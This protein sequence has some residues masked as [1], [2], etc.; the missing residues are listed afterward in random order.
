MSKSFLE[1]AK[2]I[3]KRGPAWYND[4]TMANTIPY[5]EKLNPEQ[6]AAATHLDG[7]LL[8]LAGAG[9]GKTAAMTSR[10]A[11]LIREKHVW[12]SEILA[13]TF[14]NKAAGEMRERVESLIG[15]PSTGMWLL[16]F[17]SACLRVLRLYAD[18]IGYDKN[19]AVYDT[20]D[21]K[22]LMKQV[23][24][25]KNID[26]KTYTPA[27]FLGVISHYKEDGKGPERIAAEIGNTSRGK[28]IADVYDAYQKALAKNNAM[29]FDDLLWK[30]VILLKREPEVLERLQNR[31]RYVMVDE[32]QDTNRM[33]YEFVKMLAAKNRNIVVVGDDDQCIY[34]WRGADISNILNFEKDFPNAKVIKLE[35][36]YRSYGN[37][38]DAAYS[39]I[40]N[41][42]SRKEKKLWTSRA[43][44]EKIRYYR[45]DDDWD[46]ARYVAREIQLLFGKSPLSDRVRR[47]DNGGRGATDSL[48]W[49]DFAVLYRTNAQSRRF[50]EVFRSQGI[51]FR[52][53]NDLG[54]YD[55]KEIR[56]L[57]AYLRLV[58]NPADDIALSRIINE[59]K[60]SIGD[61]S[62]ERIRA[63]AGLKGVPMLK[64]LEDPEVRDILSAKAAVSVEATVNLLGDLNAEQDNLKVSD[65]YVQLLKKTGYEQALLDKQGDVESEKRLENLD[66]LLND[67]V[68]Y[69]KTCE[70][71]GEDAT[72]AGFL[73]G[74]SLEPGKNAGDE[75]GGEA[76]QDAVSLMTL[77]TA[78]GLEFPVV[79]LVG[80]D[81]GL[82]PGFRV[83]ERPEG[84]EEE[85]RLCYVGMTRAMAR[86]YL[87]SAERRTIYGSSSYMRESQ[88]LREVDQSLLEGSAI[89]R[90]KRYDPYARVT[91]RTES[92]TWDT[93]A[94]ARYE[95]PFAR[96]PQ[97]ARQTV[98]ESDLAVGDRVEHTKFG[99]GTIL[100][101]GSGMA[102][103]MFDDAGVKKLALSVAPLKKL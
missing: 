96:A 44:G 12:P 84:I 5:L 79:F 83:N 58:N 86:L 94:K 90:G 34:E 26:E 76:A 52:L 35:Q 40:K 71:R 81:D 89:D 80:L 38:L 57:M 18:R 61:K 69:E 65:I 97:P 43:S 48:A 45:A 91:D 8:I 2:R 99:A 56:D 77:H 37:I 31:F 21:Q 100:E 53:V 1:G 16:T 13:V 82:F 46:E 15:G 27:F 68:E 66:E 29:D 4:R 20:T 3:P 74:K 88:F 33:Q 102:R 55:R 28:L 36:N 51:P 50:E 70:G 23:L 85:R 92:F 19:F 17:H 10:I 42:N 54:F 64:A 22:V 24:R 9:S 6:Y 67:I 75:E 103:V 72:L 49:S 98:K 60:R 63:M 14:T 7:P 95:S 39:V 93:A 78:K 47:E 11:W 25:A 73:E 32:Y 41:N 101:V 87:T 62:V 59:P 30:A